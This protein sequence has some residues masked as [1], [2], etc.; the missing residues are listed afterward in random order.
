M[1]LDIAVVVI[2]L[3]LK[4][5]VVEG[6]YVVDVSLLLVTV[7]HAPIITGESASSESLSASQGFA[8]MRHFTG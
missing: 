6:W 1:K 2:A 7:N 8:K 4:V 5:D 3:E